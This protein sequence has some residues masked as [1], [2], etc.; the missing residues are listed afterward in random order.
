MQGKENP[1]KKVVVNCKPCKEVKQLRSEGGKQDAKSV[2]RSK[3]PARKGGNKSVQGKEKLADK[4]VNNRKPD[5]KCD[6]H[7]LAT[8]SKSK[9]SCQTD[10]NNVNTATEMT[11]LDIKTPPTAQSS[12]KQFSALDLVEENADDE[13]ICPCPFECGIEP[14]KLPLMRNHI[15]VNHGEQSGDNK[16]GDARF[17]ED[18]I[19]RKTFMLS[20]KGL[21]T[22]YKFNKLLR[23]NNFH[24]VIVPGNGYC[25]ISALLITLAEQGVNK[26]MAVLAHEV[27]TEIR[28]HTRFYQDFHDSASEEEFLIIIIIIIYFSRINNS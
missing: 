15:I 18:N 12:P 5:E 13:L 14:C 9:L 24:E 8:N 4:A 1:A 26:E 2:Q 27:M 25:C 21:L 10:N 6:S 11:S 7:E 20:T 16:S 23:D 22:C 19:I 3:R 28:N 17:E